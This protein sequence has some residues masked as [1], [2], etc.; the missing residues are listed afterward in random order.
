MGDRFAI[1]PAPALVLGATLKMTTFVVFSFYSPYTVERI[2]TL[3]IST[4]Y[5]WFSLCLAEMWSTESGG[6]LARV[7]FEPA[8]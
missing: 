1:V 5:Y 4:W 3:P 8:F 2:N 6:I 7:N